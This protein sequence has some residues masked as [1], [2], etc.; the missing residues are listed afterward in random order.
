[1]RRRAIAGTPQ[2]RTPP[3]YPAVDDDERELPDCST[4]P[5]GRLRFVIGELRGIWQEYRHGR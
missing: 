4:S 1:M 3:G 2:P 5:L